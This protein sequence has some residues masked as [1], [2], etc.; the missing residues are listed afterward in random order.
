[1]GRG[2]DSTRAKK[3]GKVG[4][5]P[6]RVLAVPPLAGFADQLEQLALGAEHFGELDDGP[7]VVLGVEID[8]TPVFADLAL[9]HRLPAEGE[10]IVQVAVVLLGPE[11]DV[12]QAAAARLPEVAVHRRDVVARLDQFDLHVA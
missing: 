12:L 10:Q 2:A 9:H 6:H 8:E 1:M 7:G 3:R 11:G 5:R 4:K